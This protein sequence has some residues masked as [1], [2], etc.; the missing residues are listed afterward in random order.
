MV[1][2][3][4]TLALRV[5]LS[6]WYQPRVVASDAAC[7]AGAL[8]TL[9]NG[10]AA[11]T[12]SVQ[13]LRLKSAISRR[14]ASASA[15]AAAAGSVTLASERVDRRVTD[16]LSSDGLIDDSVWMVPLALVSISDSDWPAKPASENLTSI[17]A[18]LALAC[19][20]MP[21]PLPA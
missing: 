21:V 4:T 13:P 15:L 6:V 1:T 14:V 20:Q 9:R 19:C 16:S 5:L 7:G 17:A 18:L 11:A 12:R 2:C 10:A 3:C 8:I